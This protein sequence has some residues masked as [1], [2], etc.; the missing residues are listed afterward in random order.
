MTEALLAESVSVMRGKRRVIEDVSV[1]A[2]FGAVH[3]IVGPNGAGKSSL[4]RALAGLLPSTGNVKIE[5]QNL[6]AL[7]VSERARRIGWV[8]QQSALASNV[9][10]YDVVAQGRFAYRTGWSHFVPHAEPEIERALAAAEVDHLRERPYNQLSGGEQRR[11][12]IGRALA[13]QA[14]I[15]FLDEPT[16]GL[17]LVHVL[18]L[19]RLLRSLADSGT[20]V[21]SVLHDLGY[22]QRNADHV[23]LLS[24]A[25]LVAQG[26]THQVMVPTVIESVYEVR[27]CPNTAPGFQL[28]EAAP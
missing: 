15:L 23:T 22:V 18:R 7:T 1:R 14:R 2:D 11:V 20:C 4:L 16:A 26:P 21:V 19:H 5:G 17:D 25:R 27:V 8:P 28:R 9:R 10:V 13:T 6:R 12:L 24:A 3:A